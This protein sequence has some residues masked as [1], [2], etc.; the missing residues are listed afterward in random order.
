ML[1]TRSTSS[2]VINNANPLGYHLGQ[3]TLFTYVDGAEYKDI[4]ASWDWNLIPG[5]TVVRNKPD[6]TST[7]VKYSGKKDFVGV[8]S[9]GRVGVAVEDYVDPLDG[10]LSYKKAWFYMGDAA[11]VS[12]VDVKTQDTGGEPVITVLEN[13]A[14]ADGGAW[15]DGKKITLGNDTKATGSTLLYGGNGYIAHGA[16]FGLTLSEEERTGNWS[17]IS[18][19]TAGLTTASIFSAY[20]TLNTSLVYTL[21]PAT[22]PSRLAK[23]SASP[24]WK[25][26]SGD[27]VSGAAGQDVLAVVFWPGGTNSTTVDLKDVG[28]AEDGTVTLSS[29]EPGVFL[30]TA[31]CKKPGRGLK[32]AVSA[33]D[34]TQK[35]T[36]LDL[37]LDFTVVTVRPPKESRGA[38]KTTASSAEVSFVLPDGGMAG[39]SVKQEVVL[40]TG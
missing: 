25:P 31:R 7:K 21:L 39:S 10:H 27:G 35:L 17:A 12:V 9:D 4:W 14:M 30:L 3:G 38:V 29:S 6:L 34:P 13:R 37:R 16:P 5:T 1:S 28:W 26:L 40:L 22:T 11:L 8:V 20:T 15:V 36:G 23:E 33:A 18:T 2:E 24:S 32:I 19:S